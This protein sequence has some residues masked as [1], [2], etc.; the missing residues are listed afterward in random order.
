MRTRGAG[1]IQPPRDVVHQRIAH[2]NRSKSQKWA[3]KRDPLLV[4]RLLWLGCYLCD[5][6]V[7]PPDAMVRASWRNET[8]QNSISSYR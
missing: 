3:E 8:A 2:G 5:A 1:D 6:M 4:C 7:P